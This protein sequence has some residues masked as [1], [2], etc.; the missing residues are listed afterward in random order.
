MAALIL[1]SLL[2]LTLVTIQTRTIEDIPDIWISNVKVLDIEQD[3]SEVSVDPEPP[4]WSWPVLGALG[5]DLSPNQGIATPHSKPTIEGLQMKELESLID[6]YGLHNLTSKTTGTS[7][8]RFLLE[9]YQKLQEGE[10]LPSAAGYSYVD[11]AIL[12]ADTVRSLPAKG[13]H[14][15]CLECICSFFFNVYLYSGAVFN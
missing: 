12:R 9:M 5:Q 1:T 3:S 7:S 10:D 11:A 14:L 15:F 13:G 8:A 6:N 2:L 4:T